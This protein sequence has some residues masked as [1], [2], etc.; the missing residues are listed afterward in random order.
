VEEVVETLFHDGQLDAS[1]LLLRDLPA[2]KA[3]FVRVL[4]RVRRAEDGQKLWVAYESAGAA[5]P[6]AASQQKI[7][8]DDY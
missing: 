7:R 1:E 5:S 4:V 6:A 8:S 2:V 3:A